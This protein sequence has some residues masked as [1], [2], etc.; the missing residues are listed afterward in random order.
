M[1]FFCSVLRLLFLA[2]KYSHALSLFE[3]MSGHPISNFNLNPTIKSSYSPSTFT[4]AEFIRIAK[5][6]DDVEVVAAV[7]QWAALERTYLPI[8]IISDGISFLFQKGNTDLV[9]SVY[10]ALLENK[11]V[12]HWTHLGQLVEVDVHGFSQGMTYA[13]VTSAVKEVLLFKGYLFYE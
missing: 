5:K 9:F 12:S 2:E 8:G 4:I 11:M 10:S 6:L 7:L 13:A 1:Y 3:A